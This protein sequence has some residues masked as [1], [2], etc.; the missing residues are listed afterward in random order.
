MISR[1]KIHDLVK[2]FYR[3]EFK[4]FYINSTDGVE[5]TNPLGVFISLGMTTSLETLTSI[6]DFISSSNKGYLAR[7]AE[8]RS[9]RVNGQYINA[10]SNLENPHQYR[11]EDLPEDIMQREDAMKELDI[12]KEQVSMKNSSLGDITE[13]AYKIHKLTALINTLDSSNGW[14]SHVIQKEGDKDYHI[15]HLLLNYEDREGVKYRLGIL[16]VNMND[17]NDRENE[18]SS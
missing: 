14:D 4:T 13:N 16:V 15:F 9:S 11:I 2:L 12:L 8:I 7:L 18:G 1:E 17:E 10:I 5:F 6:C 3:H